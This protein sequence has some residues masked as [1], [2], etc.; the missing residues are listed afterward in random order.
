MTK[1]DDP[2]FDAWWLE[3]PV[4]ASAHPN[5]EHSARP[6]VE[7]SARPNVEPEVPSDPVR[8]AFRWDP[9]GFPI[10]R[11]VPAPRPPAPD[12]ERAVHQSLLHEIALPRLRAFSVRLEA[13]GH[14]TTIDARLGERPACIRL[15]LKPALGPFDVSRG[16]G[17]VLEFVMDAEPSE[18]ATARVWLDTF[19]TSPAESLRPPGGLVTEAWVDHVVLDFVRRS[20]DVR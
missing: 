10:R 19:D 4:G 6:N 18:S 15:R 11:S 9:A 8:S 17:S 1:Q 12:A 16:A 20:L 2:I 7:P 3:R 5:V 13:A 14:E